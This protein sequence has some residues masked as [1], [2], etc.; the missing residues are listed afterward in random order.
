VV[1]AAAAFFKG[2]VA[3]KEFAKQPWTNVAIAGICAIVALALIFT[4]NSEVLVRI[5]EIAAAALI[6]WARGRIDSANSI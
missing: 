5:C 4:G 1:N 6:G 3:V 2:T